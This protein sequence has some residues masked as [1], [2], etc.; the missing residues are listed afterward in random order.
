MQK[1]KPLDDYC[2]NEVRKLDRD[3]FV[4]SLFVKPDVRADL[5]ALY[6][7]NLEV[8]RVAEVVSEPMIGE[9]RL[10]WWREAI[11]EIYAGKPRKHQ[12]VEALAKAVNNAKLPRQP[13]D[14]L[15]DARAQDLEETPPDTMHNFVNY[16]EGTSATLMTQAVRIAGG[17]GTDLAAAQHGGIAWALTGLLRAIPFHAAQGRVVLPNELMAAH[18]VDPHDILH[19]R[20]DKALTDAVRSVSDEAHRF[21]RASRAKRAFVSPQAR[22]VLLP[23]LLAESY[24]ETLARA[25]FDPFAVNYDR[26]AAWRHIKLM[27]GGMRSRY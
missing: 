25:G 2:A 3:R 1:D 22:A 20:S 17:G 19:G 16:A 18:N 7:F 15:I 8:S 21:V 6:A 5:M 14:T 24:L 23:V 11:D 26:G 4:C 9:I 27:I 12:V 10:Q 13:F